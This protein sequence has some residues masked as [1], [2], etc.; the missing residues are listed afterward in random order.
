MRRRYPL[1]CR[2]SYEALH[3]A[4][5][6]ILTL[7]SPALAAMGRFGFHIFLFRGQGDIYL[8]F[9]LLFCSKFL[10]KAC[11]A[12]PKNFCGALKSAYLLWMRKRRRL[13]PLTMNEWMNLKGRGRMLRFGGRE[14]KEG[15]INQVPNVVERLRAHPTHTKHVVE[16]IKTFLLLIAGVGLL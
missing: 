11:L 12:L 9:L 10:L 15:E 8:Y 14:E 2:R 5:V 4:L 3:F 13:N 16:V 1:L 7:R 6:F